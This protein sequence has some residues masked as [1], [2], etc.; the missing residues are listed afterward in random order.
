V[1]SAVAS[2]NR[3]FADRLYRIL[4]ESPQLPEFNE[5]IVLYLTRKKREKDGF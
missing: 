1:K 2:D 3:I 5:D 4:F